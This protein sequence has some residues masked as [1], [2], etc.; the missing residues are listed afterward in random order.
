MPVAPTCVR[1]DNAWVTRSRCALRPPLLS[2][3]FAATALVLLV[4]P[5][6]AAAQDVVLPGFRAELIA[7]A[8][9]APADV[10]V[11]RGGAVF[12]SERGADRITQVWPVSEPVPLVEGIA[13]PSALAIPP[14]R[15]A[16]GIYVTSMGADGVGAVSVHRVDRETGEVGEA[17]ASI[18]NN[19]AGALDIVFDRAGDYDDEVFVVDTVSPDSVVRLGRDLR[20][21]GAYPTRDDLVA[22]AMG[23]GGDFGNDLYEAYRGVDGTESALVH[24]LPSGATEVLVEGEAL[25]TP[26]AIDFAP[27]TS[28][29]GDSV[30]VLDAAT[31]TLVRL[32]VALNLDVVAAELGI[33]DD[34]GSAGLAFDQEGRYLYI[35]RARQGA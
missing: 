5:S 35:A 4:V 19:E 27:P 3:A 6:G 33:D 12:V 29:F 23:Q 21:L 1:S 11:D 16:A 7:D 25:G 22:L 31:D 8:L 9:S 14:V 32:D 2:V 13:G 18:A 28:C 30:Y 24:R 34:A 17:F 26:S 20:R 10:V 15:F